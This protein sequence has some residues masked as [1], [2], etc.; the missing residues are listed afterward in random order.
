ML[1]LVV[2]MVLSVSGNIFAGMPRV[3]H[4]TEVNSTV[5]ENV[6]LSCQLSA[7]KEVLQVTWQKEGQTTDNIATYSPNHGPRLLGSYLD[8]VRVTQSDLNS[9]AITLEFVSLKDEG[10]YRCIFNIFPIGP[11][12]GRMCLN[13]Y[14]ISKPEVDAQLLTREEG[15][16]LSLSCRVTGKPAPKITWDLPDGLVV[17]PQLSYVWHPNKTVTVIS[18]FTYSPA[19]LPQE[20]PIIC[21]IQHPVLNTEIELKYPFHETTDDHKIIFICFFSVSITAFFLGLYYCCLRKQKMDTCQVGEA[22]ILVISWLTPKVCCGRFSS[23]VSANI[24]EQQRTAYV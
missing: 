22:V 13:V 18:N 14:A 7:E 10:C 8:H 24:T 23:K 6:T 2:C 20:W 3:I 12:Q 4:K 17:T 16:V 11:V 15:E 1:L 9:S 5:G 19:Q 21:M